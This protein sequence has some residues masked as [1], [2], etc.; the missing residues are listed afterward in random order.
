[1]APSSIRSATAVLLSAE[2]P[3]PVRPG[4][5]HV[6]LHPDSRS[7][8]PD[9]NAE[10]RTDR[11]VSRATPQILSIQAIFIF[12]Y[13]RGDE[14]RERRGRH[15]PARNPIEGMAAEVRMD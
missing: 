15:E 4:R 12:G 8:R 3:G 7:T 13:W 10:S 5:S 9:V 14:T 2:S 11:V 1:M 6:R